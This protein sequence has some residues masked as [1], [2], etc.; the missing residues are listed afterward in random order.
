MRDT[1]YESLLRSTR[2]QLHT[3]IATVLVK[4]FPDIAEMQPEIVAHHFSEAGLHGQ[5]VERESLCLVTLT[6]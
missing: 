1:A 3:R 6:T 4:Q 2:Q 5:A